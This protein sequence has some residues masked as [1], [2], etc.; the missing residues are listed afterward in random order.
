MEFFISWTDSDPEYPLYDANCSLLISPPIFP[1]TFRLTKLSRVPRRVLLDS[2]AY[3]LRRRYGDTM[4]QRDL[5]RWQMEILEGVDLSRTKVLLSHFDQPLEPGISPGEAYKRMERT[6]AHAW[7]FLTLAARE[8]LDKQVEL[9]GVVQGYD[10]DSI[11]W[12]SRELKRLGFHRFGVGSLAL[13]YRPQEIEAR[14]RAAQEEVGAGLHVFGISSVPIL[15]SLRELGVESVDSARPVKEA[16]FYVLLY[17]EPFRRFALAGRR[18]TDMG[19]K[20][21]KRGLPCAC[22]ICRVNS[23]LMFGVGA[24]RFT[25]MR[26]IHNYWHLKREVCGPEAWEE[27]ASLPK[28]V[29]SLG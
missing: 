9:V 18:R 16:M 5:F 6:I 15:R 1:R 17:S 8:G 2:G 29:D 21:L 26:A 24:K 7:D 14:V 20:Q 27:P 25:N 28:L 12:C 19:G 11:R 10:P 22:P 4:T 23:Q 3:T 13:L